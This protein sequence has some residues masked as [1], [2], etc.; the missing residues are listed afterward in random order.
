MDP[1]L[2]YSLVQIMPVDL[3]S[4]PPSSASS[5]DVSGRTVWIMTDWHPR[6]LSLTTI[7]S[8][9]RPTEAEGGDDEDDPDLP[10]PKHPPPREDAVMYIGPD[11][12]ALVQHWLDQGSELSGGV[13]GG[14]ASG[15]EDRRERKPPRS[16]LDLCAGSGIQALVALRLHASL[17]TAV[18]VDVNPRALRFCSANAALNRE[19]TRVEMIQ[20]DLIS[21]RCFRFS[22]GNVAKSEQRLS[23]LL[24][25]YPPF[26]L[27][28]ANPPFLP[29]PPALSTRHGLF[30]DGGGSG[31]DVLDAAV[32][33][34]AQ[35]LSDG[36]AAA[37][38]SEFFFDPDRAILDRIRGWWTSGLGAMNR[39]SSFETATALLLTNERPVSVETYAERRS[40][41]PSEYEDWCDHLRSLGV[42][43]ASPGLLVLRRGGAT[44]GSAMDR[45]G[46]AVRHEL[47][48]QSRVGSLWTPSNP[49]A[50]AFTR[51]AIRSAFGA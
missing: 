10:S 7:G 17:E 8:G 51:N 29:V 1:T 34:A 48:P 40:G 5:D 31:E 39:R 33:L 43:G 24:S 21:G 9:D 18:C 36:G 44:T 41:S 30:S 23:S 22:R 4:P 16:A 11:S 38:V 42:T 6:A 12:L 14:G 47:V 25:S 20:A 32:R 35:V 3:S 15:D 49:G 28:T 19:T 45:G 37:V 50:T 26:G 27:V 46:I 2:V 13:S